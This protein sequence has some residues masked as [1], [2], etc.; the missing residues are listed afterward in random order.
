MITKEDLR[1]AYA[2]GHDAGREVGYAEGLEAAKQEVEPIRSIPG[3]F[4]YGE[5]PR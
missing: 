5:Y 4:A 1:E 2:D 3:V